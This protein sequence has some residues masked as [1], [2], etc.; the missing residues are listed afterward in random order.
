MGRNIKE[1]MFDVSLWEKMKRGPQVILLKDAAFISAFTGLQSGDRVV[2]VGSGS[3]FLAIYLGS[4]VAP[5][6]KVFTYEKREEFAKL[7]LRNIC[8]AELE[9]VVE[10]KNKDA[11]EGLEEG[12]VDLVT[13][14]L[15]DSPKLLGNAFAVLKPNGFCVGYLPH[16]EQVQAFVKEG[17]AVGFIQLQTI[18]VIARPMLVRDRGF[19]PE[20]SG[21]LHTAYLSFLRKPL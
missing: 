8:K 14:D 7:S 3:G 2:D 9:K 19:R 17:L 11:F 6:G 10:L 18:E 13:L 5:S 15:A 12:E 16:A 4:I 20:N 21:L 1:V